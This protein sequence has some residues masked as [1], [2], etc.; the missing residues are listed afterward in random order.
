MSNPEGGKLFLR[1]FVEAAVQESV[2]QEG[3]EKYRQ[4]VEKLKRIPE[5]IIAILSFPFVVL[6][7]IFQ[8]IVKSLKYTAT[9]LASV[10]TLATIMMIMHI[11]EIGVYQRRR[12]WSMLHD[13]V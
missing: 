9:G 10:L 6:L 7:I 2:K 12:F 1:H 8:I 4:R 11:I 5:Y 3:L 13:I